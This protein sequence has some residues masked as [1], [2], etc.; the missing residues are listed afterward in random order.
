[1]GWKKPCLFKL[2]LL[3]DVIVQ[4]RGCLD[5]MVKWGDLHLEDDLQGSNR[6]GTN[7]RFMMQRYKQRFFV[8]FAGSG[9]SWRRTRSSPKVCSTICWWLL[10][11]RQFE[12]VKHKTL[13]EELYN[14]R[15]QLKIKGHIQNIG[16]GTFVFKYEF[17]PQDWVNQSILIEHFYFDVEG[18]RASPCCGISSG[19]WA[20]HLQ[21]A[22]H[23]PHAGFGQGPP[24]EGDGDGQLCLLRPYLTSLSFLGPGHSHYPPP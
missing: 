5:Q 18:K 12:V 8:D 9:R 24:E 7:K 23:T 10:S 1:M 11:F 15:Y 6:V 20:N 3:F 14:D 2:D 22:Q 19:H 4:V 13:I 16:I 17:S 21:P